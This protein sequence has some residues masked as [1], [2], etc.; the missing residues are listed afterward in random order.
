MPTI[1][2]IATRTLS[3]D[4]RHK[5]AGHDSWQARWPV[6]VVLMALH[7]ALFAVPTFTSHRMPDA[8]LFTPRARWAQ[9]CLRFSL[10]FVSLAPWPLRKFVVLRGQLPIIRTALWRPSETKTQD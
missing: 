3:G 9:C 6:W 4:H 10:F 8:I 5:C 7:Y 2:Y 1:N